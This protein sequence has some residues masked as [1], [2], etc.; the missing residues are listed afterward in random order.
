MKLSVIHCVIDDKFIDDAIFMFNSFPWI[1]N[2]YCIINGSK[3]EYKHLK[4]DNIYNI[5][6]DDFISLCSDPGSCDIVVFHGLGSFP[7]K[8]A[9]SINKKIKVVWLS[10][11]YDIYSNKWP[12]I[13]LINIPNRI[14]ENK[15]KNPLS[16][17]KYYLKAFLHNG[18]NGRRIFKKAINRIDY[19]SGVFP[20]E[21]DMLKL[22]PFF[23]AKR[24]DFN[25]AK[26]R[27]FQKDFIQ[28]EDIY[29]DNNILIGNSASYYSNHIDSFRRVSKLSLQNRRI[30]VPLSYGNQLEYVKR[31][32]TK[33]K[34]LFG[35][36]YMPLVDFM[37]YNEYV[38]LIKS[39][40]MAIFNIEQQAA[41]GN[42]LIAI[43]NGTKVFMPQTS[44]GYK[45]F[46]GIGIKIYSLETELTQK[47]IDTPLDKSIV[48]ANRAIICDNYSFEIVRS[49]LEKSLIAIANDIGAEDNR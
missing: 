23:R 37:P 36:N 15:I 21:Y 49:K 41:V 2:K 43:W 22:H 30:I 10:W 46:N 20:I 9:T 13:K 4:Y 31:I 35:D 19:Y 3:S 18:L 8:Y 12:Q 16:I 28:A 29:T 26:P 40:S 25:Y 5:S 42:I 14:K 1:K 39:C 48:M 11:G 34:K 45:H 47:A 17:F 27:N 6:Q 32:I 38:N 33:G 24:I 44:M 7:I